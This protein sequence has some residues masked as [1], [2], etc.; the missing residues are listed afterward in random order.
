[1]DRLEYAF[2]RKIIKLDIAIGLIVG[3]GIQ[4]AIGNGLYVIIGVVIALFNFILNGTISHVLISKS[5]S[6]FG[7]IYVLSYF[8]RILL[9]GVIGCVILAHNKY[10]VLIYLLGYILHFIS[11][12]IIS[13]SNLRN[14]EG[15]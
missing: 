12:V 6:F 4:L 15:K 2:V 10:S 9:A 14:G 13:A 8:F 5:G 11:M 7:I 1:M 3:F